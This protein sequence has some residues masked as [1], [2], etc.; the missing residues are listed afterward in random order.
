MMS[1]KP[2]EKAHCTP[3]LLRHLAIIIYDLL[4]LVAVLF[5]AVA[6]ALLFNHGESFAPTQ[7]LFK[8]YL[9]VVSF[10]Y[11]GWFWTHSGQTLGM[12]TWKTKLQTFD[13]RT[14]TWLDSLKRFCFAIISWGVL[15]LGFLWRILDKQHYTSYDRLSK[16]ALFFECD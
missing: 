1:Q 7:Y 16:T 4:L 15:G 12:K 3:G 14:L 9:L 11:Y 6:I 8:L 10:F 13:K 2:G 5:V